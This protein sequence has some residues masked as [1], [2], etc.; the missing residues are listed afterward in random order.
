MKSIKLICIVGA[1]VML[2]GAAPSAA[3]ES[4]C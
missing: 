3:V 1:M 4:D 2:A